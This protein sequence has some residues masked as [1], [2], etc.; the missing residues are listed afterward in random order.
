MTHQELSKRIEEL[1]RSKEAAIARVNALAGQIYEAEFWLSQ[2]LKKLKKEHC[3][4]S[5]MK[6]QNEVLC[7][8]KAF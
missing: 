7:A 5:R 6:L 4:Q 3:A 2:E 8:N 1:K